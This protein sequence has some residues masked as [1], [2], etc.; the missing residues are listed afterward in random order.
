MMMMREE[1]VAMKQQ[2]LDEIQQ[3]EYQAYVH[4]NVISSNLLCNNDSYYNDNYYYYCSV[5]EQESNV[6]MLSMQPNQPAFSKVPSMLP[7]SNPT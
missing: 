1:I 4:N 5:Q 3:L 2:L 7:Y 6:W